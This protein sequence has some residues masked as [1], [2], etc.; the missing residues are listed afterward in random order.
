[1]KNLNDI[2]REVVDSAYKVHTKL[3]PGLFETVYE[4]ALEHEI[5]KKD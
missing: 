2:A 4:V 1:M 5:R 3:G